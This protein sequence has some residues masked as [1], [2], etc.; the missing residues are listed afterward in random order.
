[1]DGF[2]GLFQRLEEPPSEKTAG[3]KPLRAEIERLKEE[4]S[5]AMDDDFNTSAALAAFQRLRGETNKLFE[6]GLSQ[7]MRGEALR[8]FQRYGRTLGLFQVS[9]KEWKFRQVITGSGAL[10]AS[11]ATVEGCGTVTPS[12]ISDAEVERLIAER[13]E[14]KKRRDFAR[15]DEIRQALAAQGITL[16]D[17]PDGTTRWKR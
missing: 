15:A 11:A 4:F 16:E 9:S 13:S 5:L 6:S 7:E 3:D 8:A 17:R 2:Y 1:M 10:V 12:V 14:A